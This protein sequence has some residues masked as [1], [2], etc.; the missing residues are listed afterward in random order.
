MTWSP[1]SWRTRPAAQQPVYADPIAVDRAIG[2]VRALP[3]LVVSGEIEQLKASLAAAQ[4]GR[5]FVLHGGDCAERFADCERDAI[6][7]K[8]KILLQMGLVLAHAARRPIVRIGRIAGQYAKPRSQPTETIEGLELPVYRGDLVN[9]IEP[10]PATREP[11]PARLV[12]G[13]FS[14]AATLNFMRA[15]VEG[16]FAD[17]RHPDQWRLSF[18][19]KSANFPAF[20]AI[21]DRISDAIDFMDSAFGVNRVHLERSDLY[22]SHEGL[23]LPWEEAFT[24]RP[25]RRERYYDL[26]A[27]FLWIG[28]R[29]RQ[30]DGAHVELF[31]GIANPIGIKVGPALSPEDLIRLIEVLS[32]DDEPGRLTLITRYGEAEIE[33]YLPAHIEAVKRAG[34]RV[35]WSVDPMHGNAIRTKSGLKTRSFDAILGELRQAFVIHDRCGTLL[36][37]V[38]FE[39]TGDDVTEC[40]GGAQGLV[41]SDL[42]RSYETGCDPRLNYGQA[43]ELAFLAA[44]MMR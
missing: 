6:V 31:R 16:G 28:D 39:L 32:P 33:N 7:R 35:L 43:L 23:I 20:Q 15:L 8:L 14:A 3:P 38:H 30:L 18:M 11:D 29:T 34:R 27:H 13:Y 5:A 19:E 17:L 21:A 25:P 9:G 40:I 41:E 1:S 4:E 2:R 44:E 37:G 36:G 42:T 22:T 12:E 26:S 24:V 10:E